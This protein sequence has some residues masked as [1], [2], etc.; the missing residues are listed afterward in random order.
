MIRELNSNQVILVSG[1]SVKEV[2]GQSLVAGIAAWVTDTAV[3]KAAIRI[4]VSAA[5]GAV[6]GGVAGLA[7][8]V[9]IAVAFELAKDD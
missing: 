8:G 4:G 9:G 5:R 7:I 2:A 1:G 6:M 3:Q